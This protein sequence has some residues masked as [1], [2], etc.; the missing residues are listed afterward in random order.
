[1]SKT[2]LEK[3]EPSCHSKNMAF[4]QA[5]FFLYPPGFVPTSNH[6]SA[7][8]SE[9]A[10]LKIIGSESVDSTAGKVLTEDL[11]NWLFEHNFSEKQRYG[12]VQILVRGK[13]AT[14]FGVEHLVELSLPLDKNEIDA[15]YIRFLLTKD[16]P[17]DI[18]A[19]RALIAELGHD[20]GFRLM[21]ERG[22]LLPCID[23]IT[24]LRENSNFRDFQK[25]FGWTL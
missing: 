13:G 11:R 23:F 2:R 19:W 1:M 17:A 3:P 8:T 15:L 24:V 14:P 21:D 25:N 12:S 20:F 5:S 22:G 4:N 9:G 7:R 16:T 6:D 18:P 10:L